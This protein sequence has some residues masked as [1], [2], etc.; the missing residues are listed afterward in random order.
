MDIKIKAMTRGQIK[1]LRNAGYDLARLKEKDVAASQDA[2]DWIFD[3]VYP[4]LAKDDSIPYNEVIRIAIAT[5]RKTYGDEEE[6]K[7]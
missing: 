6:V 5:Y 2:L 4:E 1:A 3:T 7:N